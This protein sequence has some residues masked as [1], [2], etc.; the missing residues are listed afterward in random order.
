MVKIKL[1][2]KSPVY[3]GNTGNEYSR[4]EFAFANIN[5]EKKLIKLN[6]DL[7]AKELYAY[8]K[9]LFNDFIDVISDAK[10]FKNIF[11]YFTHW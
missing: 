5:K 11:Y 4:S 10:S 2:T 3:I 6:L 8:D 1:E 9:D 7:I